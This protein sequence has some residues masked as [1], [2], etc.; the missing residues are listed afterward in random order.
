MA[1]KKR[2]ETVVVKPESKYKMLVLLAVSFVIAISIFAYVR[3]YDLYPGQDFD[4]DVYYHIKAGD[5]FP[6]F[7][8]TKEFSWTE[9]S[10]WKTNFYDKE[11]GFHGVIFLLRKFSEISGLSMNPPFN[12]IDI[13]LVSIVLLIFSWGAYCYCRKM[14]LL[15]PLLLVSISPLFLT[16]LALVRPHLISII[17]FLLVTYLVMTDLKLKAKCFLS[18]LL[19]WVYAYCYSSPQLIL[20]PLFV[21]ALTHIIHN[22]SSN[23]LYSIF[24]V[25]CGI[26]GIFTSLL[27]HPQFSNSLTLWYIQ[28]FD[29][30]KTMLQINKAK[31]GIGY[32][33]LPPGIDFIKQNILIFILLAI[34]II[35][36]V[37]NKERTEKLKFIIFLQTPLTLG[38]IFSIRFIEYA[39][40]IGVLGFAYSINN[41]C[42]RSEAWSFIPKISYLRA[43]AVL[44]VITLLVM[45]PVGST[46]LANQTRLIPL[47]DFVQW[48]SGNLKKGTYIGLLNWGDF[49]RI[50]YL[51]QDYRMSG[52]LDPMF[53]YYA[54]P[55]RTEKIEMFR[56]GIK[57][58]NSSELKEA[59]GT[60]LV[61]AS[62]YDH[63]PVMYLL[64]HGARLVYYDKE[65]CLLDLN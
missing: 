21:Y 37:L 26:A 56:M 2:T 29:V 58:I 48:V 59:F 19:A 42:P 27:L 64:D 25:P 14:S 8:T 52:A 50:F 3:S 10:V 9:M 22:R 61:Y 24:L 16:R 12:F 23:S 32:E 49:P 63:M 20:I 55:E 44:G 5:L 62:K 45:I 60:N 33:L 53:S 1:K 7:S 57:R 17:F 18:F 39:V 11:L 13:F 40:P 43:Q 47:Y 6:Y 15:A 41:F 30:I 46:F 38:F 35:L 54:Y 34:D 65:G 28:G 36:F 31:I 4:N 51:T